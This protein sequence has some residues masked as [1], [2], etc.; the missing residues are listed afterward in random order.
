[1]AST[2]WQADQRDRSWP[3]SH[4]P[5]A[6]RHTVLAAA[7]DLTRDGV[8]RRHTWL[9]ACPALDFDHRRE[10][11]RLKSVVTVRRH[12]AVGP[13]SCRPA[14]AHIRASP[15]RSRTLRLVRSPP[16]KLDPSSGAPNTTASSP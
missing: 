8:L 14:F 15:L 4:S 12:F 13:K 9:Q 11:P 10:L 6:F 7:P 3:V 2:D 1:M 5:R 16:R